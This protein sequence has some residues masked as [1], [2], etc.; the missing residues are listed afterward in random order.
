M[1]LCGILALGRSGVL[2]FL[3]VGMLVYFVMFI[4]AVHGKINPK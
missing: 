2:Q 1:G 3:P 4:T